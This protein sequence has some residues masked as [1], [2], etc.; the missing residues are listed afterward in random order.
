MNSEIPAFATLV[1]TTENVAT[2]ILKRLRGRWPEA[3]PAGPGLER[4]RLFETRK[5]IIELRAEP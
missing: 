1:P 3:F 4:I 2:D 5:N